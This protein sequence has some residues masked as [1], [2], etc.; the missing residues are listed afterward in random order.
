MDGDQA[1]WRGRAAEG[2]PV[3]VAGTGGGGGGGQMPICA[4]GSGGGCGFRG[5]GWNWRGVCVSG[6]LLLPGKG[7]GTSGAGAG[8]LL[9][10]GFGRGGFGGGGFGVFDGRVSVVVGAIRS[11]ASDGCEVTVLGWR[12]GGCRRWGR[13]L[14][15]SWNGSLGH[16]ARDGVWKGRA[17]ARAGN[18]RF[19]EGE[20]AI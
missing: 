10:G 9:E 17:S 1:Q 20:V 15:G 4:V 7:L 19:E 16:G 14:G 13:D 12:G 5:E 8:A 11:R 6:I 3:G 18:G 2:A